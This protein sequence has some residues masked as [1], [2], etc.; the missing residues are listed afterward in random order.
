[1]ASP[2]FVY[3]FDNVGPNRFVEP[4]GLLFGSRYKGFLLTGSGADGGIDG[5]N[6]P[7]LGELRPDSPSLLLDTIVRPS[8]LPVFQFKHKVVAR[9]GE[10]QAQSQLLNLYRSNNSRKSEVQSE[11]SVSRKPDTYVLVT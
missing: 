2:T 1:M 3:A 10:A 5:E 11:L 7:I 4:C 8:G 9:V 6:E